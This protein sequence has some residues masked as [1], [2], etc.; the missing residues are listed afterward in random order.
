M[1]QR[2]L[3]AERVYA[4]L[5][6]ETVVVTSPKRTDDCCKGLLYWYIVRN[7]NYCKGS[8]SLNG[9]WR[10]NSGSLYRLSE[11]LV[12]ISIRHPSRK[13][14]FIKVKSSRLLRGGL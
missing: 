6:T 4:R 10:N 5:R 9:K 12:K 11:S 14:K 1:A 7:P 8:K 13:C 3:N 2:S